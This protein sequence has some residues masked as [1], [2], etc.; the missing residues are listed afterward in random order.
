MVSGAWGRRSESYSTVKW[1]HHIQPTWGGH[2]WINSLS[3]Q[4][5]YVTLVHHGF[6]YSNKARPAGFT[7][8]SLW[9]NNCEISHHKTSQNCR[10][11]FWLLW[12]A[13]SPTITKFLLLFNIT[14][15]F[16]CMLPEPQISVDTG[17]HCTLELHLGEWM[18]HIDEE[19]LRKC[20]IQH[21]WIALHLHGI[22]ED[23]KSVV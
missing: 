14:N 3:Y 4:K 20:A 23:R 5:L 22:D 2:R 7:M 15:S 19:F 17:N 16:D 18:E 1:F 6:S 13:A 12:S 21:K 11:V 9:W 8:L 10:L